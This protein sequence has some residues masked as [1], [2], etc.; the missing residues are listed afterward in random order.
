[1]CEI[2]RLTVHFNQGV[3]PVRHCKGPIRDQE[4]FRKAQEKRERRALKKAKVT[5]IDVSEVKEWL[6]III[7]ELHDCEFTAFGFENAVG[8][9]HQ[10]CVSGGQKAR[11]LPAST[12]KAALLQLEASGDVQ[13]IKGPAGELR[14]R[15]FRPIAVLSAEEERARRIEELEDL[16]PHMQRFRS[17]FVVWG[18][19]AA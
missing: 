12:V 9:L 5:Q 15:A 13:R 19:I 3:C 2:E 17:R 16:L 10:R 18:A 11:K 1:M 8:Q 7:T 14:F 4:A 6:L